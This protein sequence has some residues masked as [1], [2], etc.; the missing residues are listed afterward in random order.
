MRVEDEM[1]PSAIADCLQCPD[2]TGITGRTLVN[3]PNGWFRNGHRRYARL[4]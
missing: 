1:C 4:R 2:K 3:I